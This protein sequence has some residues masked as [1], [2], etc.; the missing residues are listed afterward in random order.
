MKFIEKTESVAQPQQIR[1][2]GSELVIFPLVKK[3][4]LVVIKDSFKKFSRFPIKLNTVLD[5]LLLNKN[6]IK[7]NNKSKCATIWKY[8]GSLDTLQLRLSEDYSL[9]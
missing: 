2:A 1:I 8:A 9:V 3:E 7:T 5:Y 6:S 4:I